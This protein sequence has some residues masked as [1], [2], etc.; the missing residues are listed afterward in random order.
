L[1][2]ALV[3]P[4]DGEPLLLY[5][6][7]TAQVVSSVLIVERQGEDVRARSSAQSTS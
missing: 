5:I 1:I 3:P 6:A 2:R 7:T 4:E